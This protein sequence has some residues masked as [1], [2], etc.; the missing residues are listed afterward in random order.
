MCSHD[1]HG[2]LPDI[3]FRVNSADRLGAFDRLGREAVNLFAISRLL[4]VR[5][6]SRKVYLTERSV[7]SLGP[8]RK[9]CILHMS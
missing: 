3:I 4:P 2:P 6:N 1:L 7:Q 5:T 8:I 9:D